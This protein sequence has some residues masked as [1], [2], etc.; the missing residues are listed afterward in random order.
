MIK[1]RSLVLQGPVPSPPRLYSVSEG[2]KETEDMWC[3]EE[4]LL[5]P[6]VPA[7]PWQPLTS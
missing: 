6:R 4:G 5:Q 3:R 7:Q 2:R 1:D